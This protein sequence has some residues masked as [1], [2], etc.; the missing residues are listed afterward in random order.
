M[1]WIM[2]NM[3][4]ILWSCH[5][6][7]RPC[8]ET[9][10][11]CRHHGIIMTMFCRR[12]NMIT[13]M[14]C[15]HHGMIMTMFCHNHVMI[16]ARSRHGSH[17]FSIPGERWFFLKQRW[18]ALLFDGFRMTIF[19]KF[20]NFFEVVGSNSV[21]KHLIQIFSPILSFNLV[22]GQWYIKNLTVWVFYYCSSNK[23]HMIQ[24][25]KNIFPLSQMN[26]QNYFLTINFWCYFTEYWVKY[27]F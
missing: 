4:I 10:P 26:F 14:F 18:T 16:M 20:F 1:V 23:T 6:S 3:V 12:H 22:T 9:R 21:M 19:G 25:F 11:P 27:I 13:A 8:Q 15:R 7:W 5:E 24:F 2:E 17:V